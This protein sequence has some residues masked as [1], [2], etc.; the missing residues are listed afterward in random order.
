MSEF[1]TLDVTRIE[2][3]LKHPTIFQ[4]FD[5][6]NEGD[7]F[8]I[9]NDHDPKPLYYQLLAER[10]DI[11]HWEYLE[12]GP[13]TWEIKVAKKKLSNGEE[14]I[15]QMA[16]KD[17][18]K[19]EVFKKLGLEFCCGG[20]MS[21]EEAC[22]DAG[23]SI[24]EVKKALD[25]IPEKPIPSDRDYNKWNLDFLADYIVNIHHG[26]VSDSVKP[27]TDLADKIN[28]VHGGAHPE[29]AKIQEHVIALLDEMVAHQQKEETILFP[30]IKQ[31]V[32]C[33]KEA[34][35]FK[36]APFGTIENPVEMM[37]DDHNA[38]ALHI[39]AIEKLSNGY[40]VPDDACESYKLY[41]HKLKEF[42]DDLHQHIHLENNIL[43][44]KAIAME[45]N[46]SN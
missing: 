2:P 42:D 3:R 8:V 9:H 4:H 11:F 45:K 22:E 44:P 46:L 34:K 25:S 30:F 1:H 31:M 14:T 32:Q 40:R 27:L 43:F 35:P 7:A 18:R 37:K 12:Q 23:V 15:G 26:F 29:L 36:Y 6:L 19:A 33:E 20:N 16:A 28:R 17:L 41:Y 21:L 24:N 39:H 10:G 13:H 5:A 38:A